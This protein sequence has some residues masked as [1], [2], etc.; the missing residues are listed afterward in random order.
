MDAL[1]SFQTA[2]AL[3]SLSSQAMENLGIAYQTANL[4]RPAYD[5]FRRA[6]ELDPTS[7]TA[8][9][10]AGQVLLANLV[11]PAAALASFNH[12]IALEPD[13]GPALF[14]RSVYHLYRGEL[15]L[16]DKDIQQARL[17]PESE[18]ESRFFYGAQLQMLLAN[19][20]F[21]DAEQGLRQQVFEFPDDIRSA[22]SLAVTYR[23]L[24]R[25]ADARRQIENLI[26]LLRPQAAL[27]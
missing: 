19:G 15:D 25:P 17:H 3:D 21:H 24:G 18:D 4:S 16:A 10:R 2:A 22:Q 5:A 6:T 27:T 11:R 9:N 23:L 1:L 26:G 13:N 20:S 14:S 12:S 7:A 8:G